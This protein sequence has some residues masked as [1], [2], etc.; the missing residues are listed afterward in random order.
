MTYGYGK[1]IQKYHVPP[2]TLESKTIISSDHYLSDDYFP[3]KRE[4]FIMTLNLMGEFT[5][6][7][8]NTWFPFYTPRKLHNNAAKAHLHHKRSAELKTEGRL[9]EKEI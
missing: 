2:K 5:D 1:W 9:R 6:E 8:F 3:L 4:S 7:H